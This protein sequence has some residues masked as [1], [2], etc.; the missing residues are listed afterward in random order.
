MSG[1]DRGTF[2]YTYSARRQDELR[3]IRE[4]Y[5]DP[6]QKTE[7]KMERLRKLDGSVTRKATAAAIA[8]GVAGT[9]VF[10]TGL[11]CF[12]VWNLFVLGTAVGFAGLAGI[13]MAH[14][15][16]VLVTRRERNKI[17]GEILRL[18]DELM[19]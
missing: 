12:L 11:S 19:G 6:P 3:R 17:R 7:D 8:T 5:E 2:S 15:V 18:T 10:G 14:P 9:L 1:T 13:I 16:Y 4:K